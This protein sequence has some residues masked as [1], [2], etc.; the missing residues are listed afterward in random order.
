MKI[1]KIGILFIALLFFAPNFANAGCFTRNDINF[2][3]T[4]SPNIKCLEIKVHKTCLGS[5]ELV[6]VNECGSAY[7]YK[8]GSG[9]KIKITG[10]YTDPDIP[11]DFVN[12]KREFYPENDSSKKILMNVKNVKLNPAITAFLEAPVFFIFIIIAL[13]FTLA[14]VA[15]IIK[16]SFLKKTPKDPAQSERPIDML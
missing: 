3:I 10:N 15:N 14:G 7:V 11:D 16:Y 9:E 13:I 8:K 5:I 12:W 6:I 4:K 1:S 2:E